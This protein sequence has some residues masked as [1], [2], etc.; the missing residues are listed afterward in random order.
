MTITIALITGMVAGLLSGLLGIGGGTI[1]VPA[2]VLILAFE[3][4]TAQ[5]IALCAMLFTSIVGSVVQYRQGNV[6]LKVA[7]WVAPAAIAFSTLGAWAAGTVSAE[8][9]TR[10]FAVALL[11]IGGRMLL[12]SKGGQDVNAA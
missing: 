9:L 5:E 1:I 4:H 12:F 2:I 8:W 7:V 11:I 6:D 3:Q 10:V